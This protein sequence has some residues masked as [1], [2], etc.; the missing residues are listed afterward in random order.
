M[1]FL[2][3]D[4]PSFGSEERKQ[5]PTVLKLLILHL[6]RDA[7]DLHL[8]L[9]GSQEAFGNDNNSFQKTDI[10]NEASLYY[11][12][13]GT[14]TAKEVSKLAAKAQGIFKEA[15]ESW[16]QYYQSHQYRYLDVPFPL[17][18]S[19]LRSA[20][21]QENT[22]LASL[23][24]DFR[25][26]S[27]F[28]VL[29]P[30]VEG[31]DA[32]PSFS[33]LSR[34]SADLVMSRLL[35]M[36]RRENKRYVGIVATDVQDRIYLA[37]QIHHNCPDT[38]VFIFGSNLLYLNR[39]VAS[40]LRGSL[41]LT[42]YPLFAANQDWTVPATGDPR[43]R[44]FPSEPAEGI[45]NAF[46][47]LLS[48]SPILLDY[49]WP[50]SGPP[51][52]TPPV[53][54]TVVGKTGFLPVAVLLPPPVGEMQYLFKIDRHDNHQLQSKAID[55]GKM[56]RPW[57]AT[58][59]F[60]TSTAFCILFSFFSIWPRSLS[61]HGY[62]WRFYAPNPPMRRLVSLGLFWVAVFLL[63][64]LIA[65]MI[66][67]P[68]FLQCPTCNPPTV[69][70]P[71]SLSWAV[72]WCVA[73]FICI[74][75]ILVIILINTIG[76]LLC[77]ACLSVQAVVAGRKQL[78]S[79][80]SCRARVKTLL[81]ATREAITEVL[82]FGIIMIVPFDF[83]YLLLAYFCDLA[84]K[85]QPNAYPG[86]VFAALRFTELNAGVS[87]FVPLFCAGAAVF[88]WC[89]SAVR[90]TALAEAMACN[91]LAQKSRTV[92]GKGFLGLDGTRSL[93]LEPYESQIRRDLLQGFLRLPFAFLL[94]TFVC[95]LIV[96]AMFRFQFN[97]LE[98]VWSLLE[99]IFE[100]F[101]SAPWMHLQ[102]VLLH[103]LLA[104]IHSAEPVYSIEGS[105]FDNLFA[106][107][108]IAA[109][110]LTAVNLLRFVTTWRDLR[111]LL[112]RVAW[113]PL[114]VM[115]AEIGVLRTG[116]IG[117][118][119][120]VSGKLIL[121]PEVSLTAPLKMFSGLDFSVQQAYQVKKLSEQIVNGSRVCHEP[122]T[123]E[124]RIIARM[125]GD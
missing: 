10:S 123:R 29:T 76:R 17:H 112:R 44:Q 45:Y 111:R 124:T 16:I 81:H 46:M 23:N 36:L 34:P 56:R 6:T 43:E 93:N 119:N 67:I 30:G 101:H 78:H 47:A 24:L 73:A 100:D 97:T 92:G 94:I 104:M 26:K 85:Q 116:R 57:V 48:S 35:T 33:E 11:K 15:L 84:F 113:H 41:V 80:N 1:A 37:E 89:L 60:W 105:A 12:Q 2:I 40:D 79:Q 103:S 32:L 75:I 125:D 31:K 63:Y 39:D 38:V 59:L 86:M 99:T 70:S 72:F 71:A 65:G 58:G 64:S 62:A 91:P 66:F 19:G 14:P 106:A 107:A 88:V 68:F 4:M 28:P 120:K 27:F 20:Q 115:C 96:S 53:W 49:G 22:A 108:F 7:N 55:L 8:W 118:D 51:E 121:V 25:L 109:C 117:P 18:I 69:L 61:S 83:L 52:L 50:F 82:C 77:G 98:P 102:R 9:H 87:P 54:I 21:E 95:T 13:A 122:S 3:S 110:V 114:S 74:I 42:T 5:L 90:R